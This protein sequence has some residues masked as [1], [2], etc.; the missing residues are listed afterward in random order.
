[1]AC[2]GNA[3]APPHSLERWGLFCG[4]V[5]QLFTTHYIAYNIVWMGVRG[6]SLVMACKL[7]S[8]LLNDNYRTMIDIDD[9][10]TIFAVLGY[11]FHPT[12]LLY[13][14]W[15]P[16]SWYTNAITSPKLSPIALLFRVR[17]KIKLFR[18]I[19]LRIVYIYQFSTI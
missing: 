12:T 1:M 19:F 10:E 9:T 13:G 6:M 7:L 4:N 15:I 5:P 17:K 14:P 2:R 8:L 18:V 16:F 3:I 11:L